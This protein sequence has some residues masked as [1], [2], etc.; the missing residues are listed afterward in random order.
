MSTILEDI[1]SGLGIP[2]TVTGFDKELLI[3]LNAVSLVLVDLGVVDVPLVF[4]TATTML[5]LT[6]DPIHVAVLPS[7]LTLKIK[8]VFDPTASAT[9]ASAYAARLAEYEGRLLNGD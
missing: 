3:H 2:L 4:S 7:Y 8:Q 9:V 6:D 1:K 5:E